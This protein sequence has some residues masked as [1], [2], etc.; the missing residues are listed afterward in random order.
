[1]HKRSSHIILIAVLFLFSLYGTAQNRFNYSQYMH[2]QGI[3]NPAY[4]NPDNRVSATAFYKKQWVGIEGAPTTKSVVGSYAFNEQ[5]A[6][7]FDVYQDQITIF[8]DTKFGLGY[9]YRLQLSRDSYL[10]FGTEFDYGLFNTDF[11]SL[12]ASDVD[13]PIISSSSGRRGYFNTGI[14]AYLH[15]KYFFGGVSAPFL[16]NNSQ[17]TPS[18]SGSLFNVKFNHIY[19]TAGGVI[20]IDYNNKLYPTLLVKSVSGAPI[21][22]DLNANF[23]LYDQLWLGG[24]LRTDRTIILSAGF[25]FGG[26]IKFIYSYDM[27]VFAISN[28]SSG[29]HEISLGYEMPF[30]SRS[31]FTKRRYR[32]T[33]GIRF[34]NRRRTPFRAK[35]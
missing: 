30:F 17:L 26:G 35:F 33:T 9:N 21:Q 7:S 29:S 2:N 13:D 18:A 16:F 34:F 28:F 27:T 5:H 14:G 15:T 6:I 24:G 31:G 11:S 25:V 23:L 12:N 10:A 3:F 22:V 20:P 32:K 19:L 8:S 1:M 4:F